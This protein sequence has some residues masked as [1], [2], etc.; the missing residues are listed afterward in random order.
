MGL[1][2]KLL[3]HVGC[4]YIVGWKVVGRLSVGCQLGVGKLLVHV[5]CQLRLVHTYDTSISIS[6]SININISTRKS[7]CKPKHACGYTCA[8][9]VPVHTYFFLHLCLCLHGTSEPAFWCW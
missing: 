2:V 1:S 3:V 8:C 4:W 5:G 6:A 9:T 7:M